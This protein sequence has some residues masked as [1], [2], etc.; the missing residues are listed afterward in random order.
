MPHAY[1]PV[2]ETLQLHGGGGSYASYVVEGE[3][4]FEY[5]AGESA[6]LKEPHP[7]GRRVSRLRRSVQLGGQIH[8]PQR[9]VLH[10]EGVDTRGDKLARLRLGSLQFVVE[11]H[12]VERGVHPHAVSVGILR[13]ARYVVDAVGGGAAR[14]EAG[15]AHVD[16]V[17]SVIDG[18]HG[19]REVLGGRK[20]FDGAHN[21]RKNSE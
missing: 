5:H 15:A 21:V 10:D 7:L 4:A 14:S 12:G 19:G 6:I 17:R 1:R 11:K 13:G 2:H 16:G 20:E 9:H 18:G 3:R 8:A